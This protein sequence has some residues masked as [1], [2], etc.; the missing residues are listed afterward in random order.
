[1][2]ARFKLIYRLRID[3]HGLEVV[4]GRPP[5]RFVADVRDV[6]ALHD[7]AQGQIDCKGQGRH[8]R[9]RF[10]NDFPERGRQA[11]RNV[12]T[13]PTRPGPSGGRRARG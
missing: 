1:M 5:A 6:P 3:A 9:L 4:S 13:P 8:A 2:L 7:I 11:I 12:W 10:S